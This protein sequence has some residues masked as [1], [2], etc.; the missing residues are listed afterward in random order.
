MVALSELTFAADGRRLVIQAGDGRSV[1][2]PGDGT[3][4]KADFRHIGDDLL[5]SPA[6]GREIVVKDYFAQPTAP[7]LLIGGRAHLDG[8]LVERLTNAGD[9][10]GLQVAEN[11]ITQT[12]Q[13]A[14]ATVD[15]IGKVESVSGTATVQ[16]ADGSSATLSDGDP[17]FLNDVVLAGSDGAVGIVF[18]DGTT[19]SL[20]AGARMTMDEMV[21]DPSSGG[22]NFVTSVMQGTFVFNTGSIAPNGNMEVRTPV[23]TIGIRGTTV[24]ARIALEGSDTIIIL[25]ADED[26]HV[27]RVV[28]Q[29]AGGIQEITEANAATTITSFFIAPT[30]PVVMPGTDVLQY[31]D[32]VLQQLRSIQGTGP[33]GN[34]GG[35]TKDGDA[36]DQALLENFDPDDLSTAAGGDEQAGEP[37]DGEAA[38]E[39]SPLLGFVPDPLQPVSFF[40]F[41]LF[42]NISLAN[43][44]FGTA[45]YFGSRITLDYLDPGVSAFTLPNSP[46]TIISGG[47][48]DD[49]ID[50]SP[51]PGPLIILGNAGNDVLTG[52]PS[53]DLIYGLGG[54]DLLIAGHG[55][56]N[57]LI[58]G[59]AD[60]DTVRYASTTLGVTVDL[61]FGFASDATGVNVIGTDTLVNI[62]NVIGGSGND[63]IVGDG[64]ANQLEGSLG[65]DVLTGGG[66]DD[67][68]Y[69]YLA[70]S[71]VT[72]GPNADVNAGK[73]GEDGADSLYGGAGN[74][75]LHGGAGNDTAVFTGNA[76]DYKIELI[77]G[78]GGNHV[79][80]T[81]LR[82]GS[83]NEGV[84]TLYD[85]EQ[86]HFADQTA[87]VANLKTGD[88]YAPGTISLTNG[89]VIEGV[90]ASG[91]TTIGA[92]AVIDGDLNESYGYELL[93]DE[94][95]FE[96]VNGDLR[97]KSGQTL[98][99]ESE[100]TITLSV[101]VT[102]S[103]GLFYTNELHVTVTDVNEGPVG[104]VDQDIPQGG[105]NNQITENAAAGDY[106]GITVHA[107]DPDTNSNYNQITY[108]LSDDAGGRFIIDAA[109][110]IVT[111][112][113]G[114][115]FDFE[116]VAS[117]E[118]VVSAVDNGGLSTS[119]TFT[120]QLTDAQEVLGPLSD[121]NTGANVVAENAAIG[122]LVGI[123]AEATDPDAG[124]TVAYTLTDNAG[125]RF[126][127]DA[128][129][130]VVTVAGALDYEIATS[131][132]I[133]VLATSSDGSS[134]SQNFTVEIG[135]ATDVPVAVDD[136]P[137]LSIDSLNTVTNGINL[138]DNDQVGIDTPGII[139]AV[140]LG[141][142]DF[143]AVDNDGTDI[144]VKADGTV[145]SIG[146]NIG[147]MHINQNGSWTFTQTTGSDAADLQ[148]SYRLADANGDSDTA[149]FAVDLHGPTPVNYNDV[150]ST[151]AVDQQ[152]NVMIVL[153]YSGS[154]D[155]AIGGTTRFQ[156]AKDALANMLSQYELA[157]DVN[158]IVVGFNNGATAM[159]A[160]G[161]AASAL[162]FID[163]LDPAGNTNYAGGITA[164]TNI[165]TDAALQ[166][167]LLGGPTTV[168]FLSDGE[169]SSGSSLASNA[170]V[171]NA[172]DSALTNNV[173]RVVAVA[174][175]PD[176]LVTDQDL[177][178]VANPNG[179]GSP[180]NAVI[181]VAN[182]SDLSAALATTTA[183]ASGNVLNGSLTAGNGDG[184]TAGVTPDKGGDPLTRLAN[185]NYIDPLQGNGTNSLAISWNGVA[186]VVTGAAA[187]QVI[188]NVGGAVTF[189]TN[190]GVMTFFFVD[191]GPR[192]AG[193][194]TFTAAAST[195]GQV[196][197][198]HY[199]TIDGTGDLDPDG[200]ANLVINIPADFSLKIAPVQTSFQPGSLSAAQTGNGGDNTL[201]GD[202]GNNRLDGAGGNDRLNG[203]DGNDWLIGGAG[204][205]ALNGGA[206]NDYLDGGLGNDVMTGGAGNDAY[207]V[208]SAGD[209]VSEDANGGTDTVFASVT[210]TLT[211]IDVE[212]L[213]L[214]GSAN[215]DGTGNSAGNHIYGNAG[216]N[217][218]SG[219]EGDDYL[220]G[221]AGNDFLDGG[222]G[223]DFMS[224]GA[225]RDVLT[226]GAGNDI[227]QNEA[228]SDNYS[229]GSNLTVSSVNATLY[230][231]I[232]DFDAA[233]DKVVFSALYDG[234]GGWD[235]GHVFVEGV[236]FSTIT[237]EY[238]GTNGTGTAFTSGQASLILD[239]NN[240]LIYDANGAE[241]GYTIVAQIQTAAGSPEITAN[242]VLAA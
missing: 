134:S 140:K 136:T 232:S 213:V 68:L 144:Y 43:A 139:D 59:G 187:G 160:W 13:T 65:N 171:R 165:L 219:V 166:D 34:Q 63:T 69:G 3:L 128:V 227:F 156:L 202:A 22:G 77:T 27:G 97:L 221:G 204:D 114:A 41:N 175:G 143:V 11:T 57:D 195:N 145:G 163:N 95:R 108:A 37:V 84:D 141:D 96:I 58:D 115:Q 209:V 24:A 241:A 123:T 12:D 54:N 28:I 142:G 230:D 205:D 1:E 192:L 33:A 154:M 26:G 78:D 79:V 207:V 105:D 73:D 215:I 25:L 29:N 129:T 124:D 223:N 83:V 135:N 201:N 148:F 126:A 71:S 31:F 177:T 74:D 147:T 46:Y 203:N 198:F 100:P 242:N 167:Q 116:G 44:T 162:A 7:D 87:L 169:P 90:A 225:G 99:F 121:A 216:N 91:G 92:I 174:M 5:I 138:L 30:Q 110:G 131:H 112:A 185:F 152:N 194:F 153:D 172:W 2:I 47:P 159:T 188:S 226:G 234:T 55:G 224:G 60:G 186:A 62:E 178:D 93:N 173:D 164:A 49:A 70:D 125:G 103:R 190:F 82:Q 80:V 66:G 200:G 56:G 23:G 212:D 233:S 67:T 18:I 193:D 104:L 52:S 61:E 237:T 14:Q 146:D 184:G 45:G 111:V 208:N 151:Q 231:R 218:L 101:K 220:A 10:H 120:I 235:A 85:M 191:T 181:Q 88:N 155:T 132:E 240:N 228:V 76:I 102:D 189:A 64:A 210:H 48:G 211:D 122:A 16:H 109:T 72:A 238:N 21:F 157:G 229:V 86:L 127:I 206:G 4:L 168:Y 94:A 113:T 35:V 8:A 118:I 9:G 15:P 137:A 197:N 217:F 183:S 50:G 17:I 107:T 236:D 106:V 51:F 180:V 20:S 53:N 39:L 182:F 161:D 98:D 42:G 179:G 38:D 196:E 119:Q 158:V 222:I 32:E 150:T 117:Y 81:D 170:N 6:Q 199:A 176:I 149:N 130:G 89:N 36:S 239:A 40:S 133:T 75:E 19:F 214:T